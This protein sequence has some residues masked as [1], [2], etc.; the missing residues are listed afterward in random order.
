MAW[1]VWGRLFNL[2]HSIFAPYPRGEMT[3]D[4]TVKV[5]V[6]CYESD[7]AKWSAFEAAYPGQSANN[8]YAYCVPEDLEA[9][10]PE[11]SL[12]MDARHYGSKILLPV[13]TLGH[14]FLHGLAFARAVQNAEAFPPS[15]MVDADQLVQLASPL[16][17]GTDI[18]TWHLSGTTETSTGGTD[19]LDRSKRILGTA[20]DWY[21]V[22]VL[23]ATSGPFTVTIGDV[24]Y[25]IVGDTV[26]SGVTDIDTGSLAQGKD[27]YVYACVSDGVIIYKTSLSASYPS[28]FSAQTSFLLGGFHTLCA[29]VSLPPAWEANM[30]TIHGQWVVP[31]GATGYSAYKYRCQYQ[32]ETGASEPTWPTTPASYV[33]DGSTAPVYWHCAP[34]GMSGRFVSNV[35]PNSIW[36]LVHRARNLDNRGM[37]Y[38]PKTGIWVDIYP[39]SGVGGATA[40]A[41]GG[42]VAAS[43]RWTTAVTF[44]HAVGKRLLTDHEFQ[45]AAEG[46][47]E[48]TQRYGTAA[49]STAGNNSGLFLLTLDGAPT[50]AAF[51][52][53]AL[54][55]G[56]SSGVSCQ[57]V[58]RLS[59]VAYLCRNKSAFTAFTDGEVITD[60]TN[61][62]D[63][64]A[65]Y[66]T[67]ASNP[68]GR[69]VSNI[70]CEDIVGCWDQWLQDQGF[71]IDGAD[72]AT[73]KTFATVNLEDHRGGLYVQS[74]AKLIAGGTH[75]DATN[76]GAQSRKISKGRNASAAT[77]TARYGCERL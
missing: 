34:M 75:T 39:P 27:Y 19:M 11:F 14:E 48:E 8:F 47:W 29:S 15:D 61:S 52:S 58:H 23:G 62:R 63:C 38:D 1:N 3:L 22:T 41:Y 51:V 64:G 74:E 9:D 42:T 69:I 10:P 49:P 16:A 4:V 76:S 17:A 66:P 43:Q 21:S 57:V 46:V 20:Y 12:W 31:V 67:V 7:A 60:G 35:I 36:D 33:V 77:I 56:A 65:G 68:R 13:H 24:D 40:S 73:A 6:R 53:G 28:G 55:S 50:P 59:N 32:G 37:T 18:Q 30:R 25:Q 45:S 5:R 71:Y 72:Y 54:I 44:G 26:V 2:Y 70:G